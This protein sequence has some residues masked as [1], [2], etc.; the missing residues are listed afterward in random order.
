MPVIL[1]LDSHQ[2]KKTQWTHPKTGKSKKVQGEL[3]FGW[4]K[5]VSHQFCFTFT[6]NFVIINAIKWHLYYPNVLFFI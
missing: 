6:T 5:E 3:P 4:E 2:E 1:Y